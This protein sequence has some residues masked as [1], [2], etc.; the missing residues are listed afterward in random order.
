MPNK[1]MI[2]RDSNVQSITKGISTETTS[3][4]T[5]N[6]K[7]SGMDTRLL[8]DNTYYDSDGLDLVGDLTS[9]PDSTNYLD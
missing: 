9:K 4:Q 8:E 7:D 6:L 5:V 1:P 2:E 3:D